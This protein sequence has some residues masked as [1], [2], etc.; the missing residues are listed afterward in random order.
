MV[1]A[2]A[3]GSRVMRSPT[4]Q[5]S[6]TS[7]SGSRTPRTCNAMRMSYPINTSPVPAGDPA[8]AVEFAGPGREIQGD[9]PRLV[10][11]DKLV[12]LELTLI[13]PVRTQA[14]LR[15]RHVLG[16][17]IDDPIGRDADL[18]IFLQLELAVTPL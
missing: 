18:G 1:S 12:R 10:D 3:T 13:H 2:P 4:S 5:R 15:E 14:E 7:S 16:K 6:R 8:D 11:R 17:W 9:L